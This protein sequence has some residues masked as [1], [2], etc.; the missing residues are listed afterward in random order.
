MQEKARSAGEILER[1]RRPRV[2][3][4][5]YL[6]ITRQISEEEYQ[7]RLDQRRERIGLPPIQRQG[8]AAG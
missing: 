5:T 1:G 4:P 2:D 8:E 7:K 3:S 6:R